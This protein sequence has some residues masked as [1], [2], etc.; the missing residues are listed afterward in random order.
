[1]PVTGVKIFVS[2]RRKIDLEQVVSVDTNFRIAPCLV[3]PTAN[4]AKTA[5]A[6][7]VSRYFLTTRLSQVAFPVGHCLPLL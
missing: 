5:H 1:M 4:R 2:R 7:P 6:G 3:A